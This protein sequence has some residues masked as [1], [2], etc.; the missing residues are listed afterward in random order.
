MPS[1]VTQN[2]PGILVSCLFLLLAHLG[3]WNR[4]GALWRVA[5]YVIGCACIATG[6][7]VTALITQDA[8]ALLT[9]LAHL[10]P[11][12]IIIVLAWSLRG[13]DAARRQAHADAADIETKAQHAERT[14]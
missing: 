4:R 6:M 2:L 3:L 8:T 5:A 13:W 12:G 7:A 9:Y 14:Y 11:G 10:V 1:F